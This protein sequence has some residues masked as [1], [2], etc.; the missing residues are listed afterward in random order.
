MIASLPQPRAFRLAYGAY[1]V[2]FYV[3]LALPLVVVAI[4]AF[5]DST[6]PAL[7][8]RGFTLDWF[9]GT[10]AP[11]VGVL[12]DRQLLRAISTSALVAV[13]VA[14]LS[15]A[16][17]TTNAF[18][19]DRHNFPFKDT[20]YVLMLVPLVIPGI[21]LGISILVFSSRL[22]GL[23]TDLAGLRPAFLRPGVPLV[24]AGQFSFVATM[25]TLVIS[26]RLR[27]FDRALE[28]AALNLGATPLQAIRYVTLPFL[29][30]AIV[31]AGI[32][33]LLMSFENFNTTLM[34]VGSDAPLT[35]TMFDRLKQGSTPALNAV[36]LLMMTAS[37]ALALV[38]ILLQRGR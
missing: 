19:F 13:W 18:L 22:A 21:I 30:P 32:V 15:V 9:V 7:P 35:V 23:A 10:E 28:E 16:V 3:Y 2:L 17:G 12:H 20:L 37:S 24:I 36:S 4:F 26:A 14:A 5:N 25:A 8:W 38:M 1:L 29:R 31:A 11:R 34:L 27:K 33:A 6:L